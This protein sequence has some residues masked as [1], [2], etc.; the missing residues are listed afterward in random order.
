MVDNNRQ[1]YGIIQRGISEV[2]I[3]NELASS[4]ITAIQK[5]QQMDPETGMVALTQPELINL[6]DAWLGM[7][8]GESRNISENSERR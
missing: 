3:R 1:Y 5:F 6:Q 7:K 4:R 8:P 2:I